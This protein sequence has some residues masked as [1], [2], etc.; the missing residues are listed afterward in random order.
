MNISENTKYFNLQIIQMFSLQFTVVFVDLY[1][2]F[3]EFTTKELI[4]WNDDELSV[5][6]AETKE[7]NV[8]KSPLIV[9]R[10][11]E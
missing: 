7:Q 2:E 9:R 6:A 5:V 4:D 1:N 11:G 10:S 8:S 3:E